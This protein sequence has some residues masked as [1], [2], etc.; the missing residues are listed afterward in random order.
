MSHFRMLVSGASRVESDAV[1]F[2]NRASEQRTLAL[3]ARHSGARRKHVQNAERYEKLVRAIAR[4]E[5][6]FAANPSADEGAHY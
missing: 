3:H 2:L 1:H 4:R 5:Q 6:R